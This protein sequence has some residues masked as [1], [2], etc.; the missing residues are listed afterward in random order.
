MGRTGR[1]DR[2]DMEI[3]MALQHKIYPHY[4]VQFHPESVGT[5]KYGYQLLKNFCEYCVQRRDGLSLLPEKSK[6]FDREEDLYEE[7]SF[8]KNDYVCNAHS[9][10]SEDISREPKYKVLVHKVSNEQTS[11]PRPEIVFEQLFAF[12]D[13]SFWLD[14]SNGRK[15]TG[16]MEESE[17]PFVDE[18]TGR[19]ECPIT[20]NSRFS[21]MGGN[22][23]P[24]CKKI[25]YWGK[26]HKIEN[27]GIFVRD[28]A[29][30]QTH[31]VDNHKDILSFL[32]E[33]ILE[34]GI[35][36]DAVGISLDGNAS[37]C[38][39]DEMPIQVPFEFL[40]GYVGYLGYE[41]WLDT[42]MPSSNHDDVPSESAPN[43]LVPTAA[44]LFA[45]RSL[46]YDHWKDEWYL[47]GLV[48]TS[49]EET[50]SMKQG[51]VQWMRHISDTML[52]I[53]STSSREPSQS[54]NICHDDNNPLLFQLKR[55]K[56]EYSADIS[57]C[58]EKIRQGES[59]E[60]CLT[61]QLTTQVSFSGDSIKRLSSTPLGLYKILREN[62]PAPFSSFMNF[63]SLH[64][65]GYGANKSSVSICCSSPERFL[66]IRRENKVETK[67]SLGHGWEF[68]PPFVSKYVG[69]ETKMIVESKP[70]KGTKPRVLADE[71]LS[72]EKAKVK[73]RNVAKDLQLS[74]KNRAEN[75]MI[76]DLLR[77]DLS[78]VCEAGSVHV[79]KLM[80]IESF[81]T[82]HQMV[83]T[84]RGNVD[85][86][87][88]AVDVIAACFP[89]GSMTGAPKL[90]SVDI[91]NKLE[92]GESRG[93]YSGCLGYI[94]LNGA[95]D[96][97]IIIRTAVVTPCDPVGN[98]TISWNV[99]IGAGGAITALS[100]SDD[101]FEEMLLKAYA[102][103]K[104]VDCWSK[105]NLLNDRSGC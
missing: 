52:R 14:S 96:M 6:K 59:Y 58:H 94:S 74:T 26:N 10:L 31:K 64:H 65:H 5:G 35:A 67:D 43:P 9:T 17:M 51:V 104:S 102:I 60:L 78:R 98:N 70:I 86:A 54:E 83:S 41:V 25:E 21:V 95:M 69:M 92:L 77:N 105:N 48:Q 97:N 89:G 7:S 33:E 11:T 50:H 63:N 18:G 3:C 4:G 85:P 71:R 38:T 34:N 72:S 57:K 91:L 13:D 40:G 87:A 23:G 103:R 8:M 84:I 1:D 99:S 15:G 100:E 90:R 68:R 93:P 44:F 53:S 46:V 22:L 24:L 49:D 29:S 101:E 73:D 47:I 80:G 27:R 88:T 79:P 76:V 75:L 16:I 81:A 56:D 55:T 19:N 62:N 20:S 82:V 66:S 39:F 36:E 28:F 42:M 32:R 37:K 30:N 45:D 2:N 61:N 12:M